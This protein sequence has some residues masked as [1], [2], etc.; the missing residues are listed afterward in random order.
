MRRPAEV[1]VPPRG[2]RWL[3]LAARRL[4]AAP[5]SFAGAL[6]GLT[7]L[8][9]GGS[10]RRV[11]GTFEVALSASRSGVPRGVARCSFEA[12]TLGHVIV[13]QS[14]E[15]LALLRAHERIHVAQYERWGPLFLLAYP[16]ASLVAWLRGGRP[17]RDNC[18][19]QQARAE[20]QDKGRAP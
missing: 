3:T 19:E 5:C 9:C 12:V 8:A 10:A 2:P 6:L 4:W 7:V 13:G 20:A 18:F 11:D 16:M 14:H 1:D 17:Y 15:S